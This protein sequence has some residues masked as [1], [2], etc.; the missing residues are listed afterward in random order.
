LVV[1]KIITV[2]TLINLCF[3]LMKPKVQ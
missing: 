1:F 3:V 2:A